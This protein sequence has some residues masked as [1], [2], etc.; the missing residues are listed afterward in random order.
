MISNI[1]TSLI[2]NHYLKNFELRNFFECQNRILCPLRN[3]QEDRND[4]NLSDSFHI[5]R[6]KSIR[7]KFWEKSL[8]MFLFPK[9]CETCLTPV[10]MAKFCHWNRENACFVWINGNVKN[11]ICHFVQLDHN[12]FWLMSG[13]MNLSKPISIHDNSLTVPHNGNYK[14]IISIESL[15]TIWDSM[16]MFE[17][18]RLDIFDSYVT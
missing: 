3:R 6:W 12:S 1:K 8:Q 14:N 7:Q 10:S 2:R 11:W 16:M 5:R 18:Y 4:H 9:K 13:Q 17:S 15:N